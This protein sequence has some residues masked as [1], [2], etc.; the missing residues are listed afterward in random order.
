MNKAGRLSVEYSF[1]FLSRVLRYNLP[2]RLTY[3]AGLH[4]FTGFMQTCVVSYSVQPLPDL[5]RP[6]N[7]PTFCPARFHKS[8]KKSHVFAIFDTYPLKPFIVFNNYS[9]KVRWI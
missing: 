8:P 3:Q 6:A 9:T 1:R 7:S 2:D 5:D 4:V